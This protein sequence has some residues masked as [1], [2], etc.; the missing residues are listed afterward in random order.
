MLLL[1]HNKSLQENKYACEL[2]VSLMYHIKY[3]E[4]AVENQ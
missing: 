1:L 3:T 2:C 4:Q